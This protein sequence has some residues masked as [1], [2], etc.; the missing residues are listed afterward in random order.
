MLR[1]NVNPLLLNR[2]FKIEEHD[3]TKDGSHKIFEGHF[4][5]P[6][7]PSEFLGELQGT[8]LGKQ[9]ES[10]RDVRFEMLSQ[11]LFRLF[12]PHQPKSVYG[13]AENL[14][15]IEEESP[16][17]SSEQHILLSKKLS[18]FRR[19]PMGKHE[20]FFNGDYKYLGH[21]IGLAIFLHEID[22]SLE[23]IG[24]DSENR[25]IKIDGDW[26]LASVA[27]PE[28][29]VSKSN[30]DIDV[31][32]LLDVFFFDHYRVFN[33]FD[34]FEDGRIRRETSEIFSNDMSQSQMF[35]NE[36]YEMFVMIALLPDEYYTKMIRM[37][38]PPLEC[39]NVIE[40]LQMRKND[41]LDAALQIESFH[42]YLMQNCRED[43]PF[44]KGLVDSV[45]H[46]QLQQ[47]EPLVP[48]SEIENFLSKFQLNLRL[49]LQMVSRIQS[50]PKGVEHS[51]SS[52][53]IFGS[54][55]EFL[56]SKGKGPLLRGSLPTFIASSSK[57]QQIEEEFESDASLT[58]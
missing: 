55:Q 8:W 24:L 46:F 20:E 11:E 58:F 6:I 56:Q 31:R 21:V 50:S 29:F 41:L 35:Q 13:K 3:V 36:I 28:Q 48:Q 33:W 45:T 32:L 9:L 25:V 18:T 4:V 39:K 15:P 7:L 40:F 10:E 54:Q 23:N 53:S 30:I 38:L 34:I 47:Q 52:S 51:F 37:C 26:T 5:H 19:L 57:E 42:D 44:L 14:I 2:F 27:H 12:L 43:A 49:L 22:L 17:L 1:H 16:S